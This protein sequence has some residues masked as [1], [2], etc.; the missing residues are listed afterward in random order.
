M[1]SNIFY[2]MTTYGPEKKMN[3]VEEVCSTCDARTVCRREPKLVDLCYR[4]A[5]GIVFHEHQCSN[6]EVWKVVAGG[7]PLEAW[8]IAKKDGWGHRNN[9]LLCPKCFKEY[10]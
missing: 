10:T 6:C 3:N 8:A 2:Q 5:I 9:K 1:N 7:M 4:S